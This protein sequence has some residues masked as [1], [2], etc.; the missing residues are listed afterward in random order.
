ML[1]PG[2]PDLAFTF[3]HPVIQDLVVRALAPGVAD[4]A[5]GERGQGRGGS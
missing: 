5:A 4:E 1:G 3:V 2:A